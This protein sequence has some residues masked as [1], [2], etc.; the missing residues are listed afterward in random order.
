MQTVDF[1]FN[2][3]PER[4]A[5]KGGNQMK[6]RILVTFFLLAALLMLGTNHAFCASATEMGKAAA[7][8]A[9]GQATKININ[10]AD[11]TQLE[12]LP[13]I[14]PS[15]AQAILDYREANGPF[16]SVE[17]LK[18]VKGIGDKKFD[19]VKELVTVE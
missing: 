15:T 7:S 9:A 2:S 17:G 1:P 8:E 13:G 14:G 12:S 5:Y 19:A 3:L 11:L 6:R 16:K 10:S 4:P 18:D